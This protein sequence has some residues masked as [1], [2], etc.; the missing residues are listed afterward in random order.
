MADPL[1]NKVVDDNGTERYVAAGGP[2]DDP[3]RQTDAPAQQPADTPAPADPTDPE[4]DQPGRLVTEQEAT[5]DAATPPA[6]SGDGVESG[7]V[8]NGS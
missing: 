7:P 5:P 8:D 4:A 2:S 6:P 3:E 1:V